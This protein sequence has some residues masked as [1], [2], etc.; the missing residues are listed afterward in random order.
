MVEANDPL[1]EYPAAK[2]WRLPSHPWH[3]KMQP[4][5][6][7]QTNIGWPG[8]LPITAPDCADHGGYPE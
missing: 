3:P 7:I 5:S 4:E 1:A 2:G 8:H 6:L